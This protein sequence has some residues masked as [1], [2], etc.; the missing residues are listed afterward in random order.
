MRRRLGAVIYLIGIAAAALCLT[1]MA[2]SIG[3]G[4]R[5]FTSVLAFGVP[6]VLCFLAGKAVRFVLRAPY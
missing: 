4:V 6:A 5:V 3:G 2:I 1:S